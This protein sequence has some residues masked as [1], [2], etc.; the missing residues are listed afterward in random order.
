MKPAQLLVSGAYGAMPSIA[1]SLSLWEKGLRPGDVAGRDVTALDRRGRICLSLGNG[2]STLPPRAAARAGA[3][4][5]LG[6][7]RV[8]GGRW[9]YQRSGSPGGVAVQ[10]LSRGDQ[11]SPRARAGRHQYLDLGPRRPYL[12]R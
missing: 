12:Y 8:R 9:Q 6:Q 10:S 5:R 4:S 2:R 3:V 1:Y 7:F 11:K